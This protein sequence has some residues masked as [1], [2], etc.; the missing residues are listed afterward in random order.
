MPCCHQTPRAGGNAKSMTA[1]VNNV[2]AVL[3]R[4]KD[5][6]EDTCRDE[7]VSQLLLWLLV[8]QQADYEMLLIQEPYE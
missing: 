6:I 7:G 2:Y 4:L 1:K 3:D 8:R 5:D